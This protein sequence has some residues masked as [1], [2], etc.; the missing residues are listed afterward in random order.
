MNETAAIVGLYG[1]VDEALRENS[2]R[3]PTVARLAALAQRYDKERLI[4]GG[5]LN[6]APWSFRLR[7]LDARLGLNRRDRADFTW[8][9]RLVGRDWPIPVLPLD[10]LYAG[11]AWTTATA[12]SSTSA[13]SR[14]RAEPKPK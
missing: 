14:N 5:D 9:A 1:A 8:P 12:A 4:I 13:T 6:L 3:R 7:R 11:P 2:M 10:H